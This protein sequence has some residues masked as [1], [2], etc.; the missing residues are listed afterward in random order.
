MNFALLDLFEYTFAPRYAQFSRVIEDIFVINEDK[1]QPL[2]TLKKPIKYNL[3]INEW[4]TIQRIVISLQKQTT[5]Q[6]SIVRKFID[7]P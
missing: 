5:T 4:D 2:F 6:A 3:I 1:Q 7:L